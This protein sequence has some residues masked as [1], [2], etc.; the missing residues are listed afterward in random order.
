MCCADTVSRC[1]LG[2][3]AYMH[4]CY[5]GNLAVVRFLEPHSDVHA[6]TAVEYIKASFQVPAFARDGSAQPHRRG[7]GERGG[8]HRRQR[9]LPR[10]LLAASLQ[11]ARRPSPRARRRC[12]AAQPRLGPHALHVRRLPRPAAYA[13][14][15][16]AGKHARRAVSRWYRR[17]VV[18]AR[19]CARQLSERTLHVA[20]RSSWSLAAWT[21]TAALRSNTAA[22][23]HPRRRRRWALAPCMPL[24]AASTAVRWRCCKR[25]AML[26]STCTGAPWAGNTRAPLCAVAADARVCSTGLTPIMYACYFGCLDALQYLIEVGS[27]AVRWAKGESS[28]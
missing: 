25:C 22:R 2:T 9:A 15:F 16:P 28:R 14:R 23:R 24:R 8:A 6:C 26:A 21:C 12:D 3:T 19:R 17:C 7:A 18:A 20:W 10:V 5:G 13:H 4:A 11:R 27:L 1:H